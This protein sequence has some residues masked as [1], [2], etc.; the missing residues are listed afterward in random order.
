MKIYS[1][2]FKVRNIPFF[3]PL[4]PVAGLG[5]EAADWI[6][7]PSALVRGWRRCIQIYIH[8]L[9]MDA[10]SRKISYA[11]LLNARKVIP[12]KGL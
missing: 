11:M 5:V 3:S 1:Q 10:Y 8:P 12:E 9:Y 6:L 7:H 2:C 4:I